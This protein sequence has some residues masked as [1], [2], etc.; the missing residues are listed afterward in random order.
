MLQGTSLNLF[1]L[2]T[3]AKNVTFDP[4][5][6]QKRSFSVSTV[7]SAAGIPKPMQ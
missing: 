7:L 6:G 3:H 5:G 1:P 4:S 2:I